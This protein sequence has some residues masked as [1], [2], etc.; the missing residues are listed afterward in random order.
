MFKFL[1]GE[2][3]RR[4]LGRHQGF[5]K[6]LGKDVPND[7]TLDIR[8]A[9]ITPVETIGQLRMVQPQLVQERCMDVMGVDA[10]LNRLV[11]EL[12]GRSVLSTSLESTAGEPGGEGVGVV[13]SA[14]GAL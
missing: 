6:P 9:E 13:I 11:A 2:F 3:L 4:E 10:F 7:L 5:L 12:I 1:R 8:Q 14:I